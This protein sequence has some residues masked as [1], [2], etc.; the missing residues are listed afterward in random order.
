MHYIGVSKSTV[1][2]QVNLDLC[3]LLLQRYRDV[4]RGVGFPVLRLEEMV[5]GTSSQSEPEEEGAD[6]SLSIRS[7]H[8]AECSF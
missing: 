4:L 3:R 6:R 2:Y 5:F 1:P 7:S 8:T